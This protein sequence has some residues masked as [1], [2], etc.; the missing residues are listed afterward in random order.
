MLYTTF[1]PLVVR[2]FVQA[3]MPPCPLPAVFASGAASVGMQ[4]I[5]SRRGR[6]VL[7]VKDLAEP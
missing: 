6:S 5:V 2:T 3:A 4:G 7:G 1:Q